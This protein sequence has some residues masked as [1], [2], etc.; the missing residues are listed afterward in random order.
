[1]KRYEALAADVAASIQSGT[2]KP[3]DKLPSVRQAS[4]SRHVSPATVFQA[5]YLLEAKGLI[6]A[7]ARS[8]YYVAQ[9]VKTLPPEPE[10]ASRP[11]GEAR[12]VEVSELVLGILESAMSR[13]VVPLGS[14][15]PSPLLFPFARLG[16]ATAVAAAKL[17]PWM[18]VEDLAPGSPA[19]RQQIALRYLVDGAQVAPDHI[20]VTNGAMEALNLCLS[21]VCK[22][23]DTV[24]VEAPCFYACLQALERLGLH[25]VEVAT[26][27]R[28]GIDLDALETA[29]TRHEPKACWVMTNFQNPLGCSMGAEKKKA[30]V[31]LVTRHRVPLIEDD[32][33]GELYYGHRRPVPTKS[34]DTEGWVMHCSSFSK[35]LA[36]GY[37]V[38][39]TS[40]GRFL[41]EVT[42]QKLTTSLSTSIPAQL[43]LARYLER[44]S[45]ERHFRELRLALAKNRDL[46]TEA[47]RQYFPGDTRVSRPAGGYFLWVELP[48][49]V[50]ALL[51]HRMAMTE[52]MSIAPGPMFSASRDFTRCVRIN[53]G[54][55]L[56]TR[57]ESA[58]GK[59]GK[60]ARKL[61]R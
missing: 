39:W 12:P 41:R 29:I 45:H 18:T 21:A 23:G 17:D 26:D 20:V 60:L 2:L 43:G 4:S 11:D 44:G 30:L 22:P 58:L 55:P 40:P 49:K 61:A 36:P 46:Y 42:Y 37:R 33:Y 9:G 38:G 10:T 56:T 32:V 47:I 25:A 19:L 15:F 27:P 3:G 24:L 59:L 8:G 48:R 1:M 14:A 34:F 50:D 31:E 52:N 54:H 6:R 35:T 16:R 28:E 53:H 51:L 13:D 7:K 57:V 5:Y